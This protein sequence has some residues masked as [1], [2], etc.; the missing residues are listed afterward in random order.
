MYV[1]VLCKCVNVFSIFIFRVLVCCSAAIFRF[2]IFASIKRVMEGKTAKRKWNFCA[3]VNYM[4]NGKPLLLFVLWWTLFSL[5]FYLVYEI[6]FWFR[7][8]L[9]FVDLRRKQLLQEMKSFPLWNKICKTFLIGAKLFL[10]VCVSSSK[11]VIYMEMSVANFFEE[12]EMGKE[13][14]FHFL[15]LFRNWNQKLFKF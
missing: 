10:C 8:V 15:K 12:L 3:C 6:F 1:Y 2:S 13:L 9:I 7:A 4:S 11:Q 14:S 5:L